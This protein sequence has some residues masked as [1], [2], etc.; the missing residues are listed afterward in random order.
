MRKT[1][2]L[3]PFKGFLEKNGKRLIRGFGLGL[4]I[5]K[6]LFQPLAIQQ[7]TLLP[8]KLLSYLSCK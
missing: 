1:L 3:K 6:H 8:K 5:L 2:G 7:T 4:T